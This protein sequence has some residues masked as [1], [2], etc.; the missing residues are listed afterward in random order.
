MLHPSRST[1]NS[2]SAGFPTEDSLPSTAT[3][4]SPLTSTASSPWSPHLADSL[5]EAVIRAIGNSIPAIISSI[6]SNPFSHIPSLVPGV[7]ASGAPQPLFSSASALSASK[8]DG[9]SSVASGKFILYV[10][11]LTFTLMSAITV[12][13]LAHLMAP[14]PPTF[15]SP[16]VTSS[17]P[18][19]ESSLVSP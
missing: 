8:S 7:S 14:T 1:N 16:G 6:Q 10:F 13:S 5:N 15:V 9:T 12:S 4:E 3:S 11:V 18:S 2:L 17:L 19:L